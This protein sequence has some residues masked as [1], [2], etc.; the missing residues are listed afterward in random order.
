MIARAP[1]WLWLVAGA[2][3]LAALAALH[4]WRAGM[5]PSR[6]QIAV[7]AL[8]GGYGVEHGI[9][10]P[11]RDGVVLAASL[12]L[13]RRHAGPLPTIYIRLPYGR[14]DMPGFPMDL[15]KFGYA[16]LIQDVRGKFDSQGEF[17]TWQHAT[18]DGMTT[19]DWITS[20]PWSNG[21]VGTFGCSSQG[22]LQYALARGG[23]PAHR[24]M[25]ASGA[26]GGLGVARGGLDAFGWFEGGILQLAS[27]FGWFQQHGALRPGTPLA[28][29]VDHAQALRTL[30][31][32]QML[33]RIQPAPNGFDDFL[34][35]PLGDTRWQAGGYDF[36][37]DGDV[38]AVPSLSINTWGDQTLQG[39]LALAA[40]QAASGVRQHVILA[41]GNHC[42]HI[43][44]S[45]VDRFGDLEI[46]N[47]A[48]PYSSYFRQW[49]D[50]WLKDEGEGLARLPPYLFYV[51]GEHQW[52]AADQWPPRGAR[53]RR[54]YLAHDGPANGAAGG[55]LLLA[56]PRETA[57]ADSYR[58]DPMDPVPSVGGPICCTGNPADRAGPVDQR[59]VEARDDVLVYTS[60][61]LAGD[62]RIAGPLRAHLVV[63]STALDTDLV[64]RLVHVWPDGRATSIQEG[65]LRLRYRD[66]IGSPVPMEPGRRYEVSVDMRS[67]AYRVPEGHRIRLTLAS[68]SFPRLAR[69]LQ[70]G[71]PVHDEVDAVVARNEVHH[72]GGAAARSYV[73]LPVMDVPNVWQRD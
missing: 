17:R 40:I 51:I 3:M 73:S 68:S 26:G 53:E 46:R 36:V 45:D 63:S 61:P 57:A 47:A 29:T 35:I 44:T 66:G 65:A 32:T 41:P 12:Y 10:I 62:L 67:I 1:S 6:W 70:T 38:L 14:F 69:N 55:G 37:G 64:A 13:P 59:A 39:T 34:T 58:S 11:M 42:E 72:G 22:E 21:R 48:L 15:A 7:R 2:M 71:G 5:V 23:H 25:V 56:Q 8:V 27:A 24:A 16:V 28:A 54:W 9:R 30:P 18:H 4:A 33:R 50:H 31:L 49:F 43:A 19:L 20:Q 60:A 52:M